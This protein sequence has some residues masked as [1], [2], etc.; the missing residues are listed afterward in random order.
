[1]IP[2]PRTDKVMTMAVVSTFSPQCSSHPSLILY[3]IRI[4]FCDLFPFARARS[5]RQ[6]SDRRSSS[7]TLHSQGKEDRYRDQSGIAMV[8][9]RRLS[10]ALSFQEPFWIS[11]FHSQASLVILFSDAHRICA[12][13]ESLA[14]MFINSGS[15]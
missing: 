11:V 13:N 7:K 5:H 10:S 8:G 14:I 1:M 3:S 4:S 12:I 9:C 6:A 2:P 15:T